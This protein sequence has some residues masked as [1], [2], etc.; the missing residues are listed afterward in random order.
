[1]ETQRFK[2]VEQKIMDDIEKFEELFVEHWDEIAKNKEVMV[3]KPD[4]EKY[5]YLEELG[6]MRT[7]VAYDSDEIVGYSVNFVQNHLHYSDLITCYNDIV[8]LRKD[9]RNSPL[10]LRLIRATEKFAKEIGAHML[11]WHVKEGSSIS[12]ILPKIDYGVQDIVYS[13]AI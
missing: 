11:L 6:V 1:M 8:Y 4:Y 12:K 10:G 3:L 5:K 7:L 2:I 13:K 9:K